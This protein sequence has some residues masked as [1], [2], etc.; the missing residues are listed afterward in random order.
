MA[1]M[2]AKLAAGALATVS[3]GVAFSPV[4]R[5]AESTSAPQPTLARPTDPELL[6][7]KLS[8]YDS[9]AEPAV[10]VPVKSPLQDEVAAA[11]VAA[12]EAYSSIKDKTA[13]ARQTWLGLE[14]QGEGALKTIISDRDQLNPNALY[15]GIATL[16]GSIVGRNRNFL[17]RLALPPLF[18]VG[19]AAYFLPHSY[20]KA[21]E[22]AGV[23]QQWRDLRGRVDRAAKEAKKVSTE[24]SGRQ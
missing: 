1:A 4:L 15:V 23:P 14:K 21:A 10:L 2:A 13:D 8:L 9:P 7:S 24:Q 3:A 16:A 6:R 18:L 17:V 22:R 19:S 20:A 12:S 11:R 5:A